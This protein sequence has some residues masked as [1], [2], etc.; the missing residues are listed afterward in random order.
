MKNSFR[1]CAIIRLLS[2]LLFSV[3]GF[4]ASLSLFRGEDLW[5]VCFIGMFIAGAIALIV[6][7]DKNNE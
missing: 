2:Y 4:G 6:A 3:V 5:S 7:T 1:R